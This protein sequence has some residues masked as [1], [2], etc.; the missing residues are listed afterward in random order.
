MKGAIL[1]VVFGPLKSI[2]SLCCGVRNRSD[3]SVVHGGM[4]LKGLFN[5]Q[6]NGTCDA[7][8]LSGRALDMRLTGR[9]FNR[10]LVRFH[11][12]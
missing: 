6:H 2:V 8:W 12:T 9:G 10:Q 11:V 5:S 3:H 7:W 4:Q 1:G